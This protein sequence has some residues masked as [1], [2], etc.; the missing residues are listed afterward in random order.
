MGPSPHSPLRTPDKTASLQMEIATG[1]TAHEAE[2]MLIMQ[3]GSKEKG[4]FPKE[5][6]LEL[7]KDKWTSVWG[8]VLK[9]EGREAA[10]FSCFHGFIPSPD[11]LGQ[12]CQ[13]MSKL[14]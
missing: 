8:K 4:S 10:P 5:H 3:V 11:Q 2:R 14:Y 7:A 12:H 13:V 9:R 6:Q 1:Q